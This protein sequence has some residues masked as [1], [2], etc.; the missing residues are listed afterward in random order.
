MSPLEALGLP[1]V[2]GQLADVVV[3]DLRREQVLAQPLA[4]FRAAVVGVRVGACP[5][6]QSVA[7]IRVRYEY[8][9]HRTREHVSTA[10]ISRTRSIVH[11]R[12]L[13]SLVVS[14]QS[15]PRSKHPC[16]MKHPQS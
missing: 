13:S 7:M 2:E 3:E 11:P 15:H 9:F 5:H 1:G 8:V 10:G 14:T 4:F 6:P 12:S 16:R